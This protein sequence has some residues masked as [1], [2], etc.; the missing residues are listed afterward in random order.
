MSESLYVIFQNFSYLTTYVYA[1]GY[2]YTDKHTHIHTHTHTHTQQETEV[3]T[4]GKICTQICVKKS[5]LK[6]TS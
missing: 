5:I 4:I 6:A 3:M 2:T 1:K